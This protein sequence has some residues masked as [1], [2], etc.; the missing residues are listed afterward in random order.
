MRSRISWLVTCML[1]VSLTAGAGVT[2]REKLGQMVMITVTGDSLEETGP[3]MATLKSDLVDRLVGGVVMFVWSENLA[4]PARIARFTGQVQALAHVPL[5]LAIDQEGGK[6]A[7][8]S[9]S[10]GFAA[11]S[12]AY[13]LGTVLNQESSTRAMASTMAG[14][15]VQTGLTMNLAPVVDVNVNPASPA[16]GALKRSFSAD[17]ATVARHASLFIDEFHAKHILTALKHF[18]GHGSAAADSHLGFTDITTT[19]S[20]AEL[21]PYRTLLA[22]GKPDAIMTGHLFNGTI[23]SVYPATLSFATITGILRNQLGFGGVVMSD[24]MG[25]KAITS[26]YGL[27]EAMVLAVN[28]GVDILVYTSNL[29]SSGNSLARRI[30]DVLE[31]HVQEGT[32]AE[33]RIDASY[34][35]IMALKETFVTGV[36]IAGAPDLPPEMRLASFPNPFNPVT[37]LQYTLRTDGPAKV[38]VIDLLGRV[39]ATPAD[40]YHSAGVHSVRFDGTGVASGVYICR[41]ESAGATATHRLALLK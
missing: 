3:S 14:W 6:V 9:A 32:I 7:R 27:D 23:D 20:S 11:T 31:R 28:A 38:Q 10:N 33:S 41:L 8:L 35:R 30:V 39:V 2:L 29:D 24:A 13:D 36:A 22:E 15:F 18:P 4:S 25:M 19:W 16:I 5:L 34:A 17:A 40:G 37:T 12:T 1:F 21:D 26:H